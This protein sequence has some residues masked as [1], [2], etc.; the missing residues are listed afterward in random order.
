MLDSTI[1]KWVNKMKTN[2]FNHSLPPI[3]DIVVIDEVYQYIK[4]S[5][6]SVLRTLEI[7]SPEQIS[8]RIIGY[9]RAP[10]ED[11]EKLAHE[12]LDGL[13][14][15]K[16]VPQRLSDRAEI[17]YNQIKKYLKGNSVLDLGCGDGKVG[18]CIAKTGK[19]VSL[20]DVYEHPNIDSISLPF[21]QFSQ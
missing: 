3:K 18:E 7:A 20:A 4:S 5:L 14:V 13:G 15:T 10:E 19:T 1:I 9:A 11:Y 8:A 6:D 2:A 16:L 12:L 21:Y 17:V